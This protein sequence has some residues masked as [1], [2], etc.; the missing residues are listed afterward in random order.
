MRRELTIA[1]ILGLFSCAVYNS[2]LRL[3]GSG[4][5]FPARYLPFALLRHRTLTL[6]PVLDSVTQGNPWPY[7]L[8]GGPG[9]AIST[10]PVAVPVLLSPLYVPACAL[11]EARGWTFGRLERVA[12]I[13]EKLVASGVASL[14]V[15]L[16]FLLLARRVRQRWALALALAYAFGTNTWMISSQALWQHGLSQV[17]L[18]ACL[19]MLTGP[20]SARTSFAAGLFCG[21]AV[22]ARPTD[23]IFAAALALYVWLAAPGRR[24]AALAGA[25]IPAIA[26]LAYNV[27][28]IGNI[29]GGYGAR[30]DFAGNFR[31]FRYELLPGLAGL[32][33][34]PARGLFVYSPFLALVPLALPGRIARGQASA[35][36]L[37]L[38]GAVVAQL[39]FFAK[40]DWRGGCSFGPRWLT[41][42]VPLL[43]WV[44][45]PA[46]QE[47]RRFGRGLF[48]LAVLASVGAQVIGAYWYTGGH[49]EALLRGEPG[50]AAMWTPRESPLSAWAIR[51]RSR[52]SRPATP[53]ST[54]GCACAS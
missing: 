39:L 25:A 40:L 5:T 35:L 1:L 19:L 20:A 49:D 21:L 46:A 30:G 37:A 52:S 32:L 8:Q 44:L 7:W 16:M 26:L 4:D 28:V 48:A 27:G 41:D 50:S 2:N 17:C 9:P 14:S 36:D 13:M 34:S 18:I 24:L 33:L 11:L 29:A 10:F 53:G 45:A 15:A 38:L 6:D 23:V 47:L 3:V 42:A 31:H 54:S 22:A 12:R 43:V 51:S